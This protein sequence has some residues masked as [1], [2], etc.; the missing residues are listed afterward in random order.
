MGHFGEVYISLRV[1]E[2][3]RKLRIRRLDKNIVLAGF[4][5]ASFSAFL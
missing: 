5:V 3:G 2:M 1:K 4:V